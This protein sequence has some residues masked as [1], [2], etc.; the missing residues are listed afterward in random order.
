MDDGD[1]REKHVPGMKALQQR[2]LAFLVI[3]MSVGLSLFTWWLLSDRG[4]W[5]EGAPPANW[6]ETAPAH[7]KLAVAEREVI[8]WGRPD[9]RYSGYATRYKQ[10]PVAVVVHHTL[11][12]TPLSLV[13]YGHRRD[14]S[15]GNASFG[16]HFYIARDGRIFQGAPM[17]RRTNHV[18][19]FK[20]TKRT[21][22]AKHI[23]SGNAIGVS[24]VGACDPWRTPLKGKWFQ[25]AKETI[26]KAQLEAG[27]AVI[28]ALQMRYGMDCQE[29]WGHGA[30]QTD[31]KDFEGETLTKLARAQ[32]GLPTRKPATVEAK[33]KPAKTKEGS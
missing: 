12:K 24:L 29:V 21:G 10:K 9:A 1:S 11:P 15:R 22:T 25:C 7:D 17:S 23:W 2:L 20:N 13:K 18:K 32:C 3:A 31:R 27:L 5:R 14:P 6:R 30:L 8:Y 16:Y 4:G 26:P 28:K 19:Y 33:G